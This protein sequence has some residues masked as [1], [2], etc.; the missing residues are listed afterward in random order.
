[1]ATKAKVT[2]R[3]RQMTTMERAVLE[4]LAVGLS[5]AET[6]RR[7]GVSRQRVHIIV[8]NLR[9]RGVLPS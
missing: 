4:A 6:A 1:M 7:L 8:E 9:L 3:P 2:Q 5:Q